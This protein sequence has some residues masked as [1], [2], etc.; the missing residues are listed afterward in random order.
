LRRSLYKIEKEGFSDFMQARTKFE[1]DE[2]A[3]LY[4]PIRELPQEFYEKYKA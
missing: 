3:A 4:N 1:K 2:I